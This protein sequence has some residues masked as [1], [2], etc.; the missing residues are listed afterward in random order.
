MLGG[1]GLFGTGM[2]PGA[3]GA[4]LM[5]AKRSFLSS[6]RFHRSGGYRGNRMRSSHDAAKD[7]DFTADVEIGEASPN[8]KDKRKPKREKFQPY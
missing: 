7:V 8:G 3:Y 4:V 5:S 6:S 1:A 2:A